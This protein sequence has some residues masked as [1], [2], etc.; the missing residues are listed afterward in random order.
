MDIT[1]TSD[2][3][4]KVI[5]PIIGTASTAA[6]TWFLSRHKSGAEIEKLEAEREKLAAE[7]KKIQADTDHAN[8]SKK[9]VQVETAEKM[10]KMLRESMEEIRGELKR[11]ATDW[12]EQE[13][14]YK[15]EINKLATELADCTEKL[16]NISDG[17]YVDGI[18]RAQLERGIADLESIIID[19]DDE[20]SRLQERIDRI[21][22]QL[23][24]SKTFS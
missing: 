17:D 4:L 10:I 16:H 13:K 6:V 18:E 19:K 15:E 14:K 24:G 11:K 7:V 9:T 3:L 20:V 21:Q 1:I 23:D 2:L 5:G 22:K 12:L 8:S